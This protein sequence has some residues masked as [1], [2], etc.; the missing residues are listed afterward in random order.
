MIPK[1]KESTQRQDECNHG[2]TNQSF[3]G[4]LKAHVRNVTHNCAETVISIADRRKITKWTLL[5]QG[6][7]EVDTPLSREYTQIKLFTELE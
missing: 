5:Q 3:L 6:K 7:S 2:W 4:A 1:L